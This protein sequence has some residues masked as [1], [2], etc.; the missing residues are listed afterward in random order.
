MICL[1]NL[2]VY[3]IYMYI[4]YIFTQVI[5]ILAR[6]IR[7]IYIINHMPETHYFYRFPAFLLMRRFVS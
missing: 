3:Y 4:R 6:F 2:S 1:V 5:T 7:Y